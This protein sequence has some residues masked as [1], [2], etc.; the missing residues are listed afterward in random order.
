MGSRELDM[1][2]L[3]KELNS[4]IEGRGGGKARMIQGSASASAAA[5]AAVFERDFR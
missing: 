4:L 3:A 1:R 2:S 5:I